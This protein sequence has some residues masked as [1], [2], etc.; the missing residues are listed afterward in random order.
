[1]NF[2]SHNIVNNHLKEIF[3]DYATMLRSKKSLKFMDT[4]IDP[5]FCG[6]DK[7][8]DPEDFILDLKAPYYGFRCWN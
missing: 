7:F 5:K 3:A 1:M 6:K 2:F 8:W 4:W